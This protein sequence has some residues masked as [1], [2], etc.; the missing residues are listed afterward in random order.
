MYPRCYRLKNLTACGMQHKRYSLFKDPMETS[1]VIRSGQ[2]PGYLAK[3]A[4]NTYRS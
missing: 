1:S 2:D 3:S 4:C